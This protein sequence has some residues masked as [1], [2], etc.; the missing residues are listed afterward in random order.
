M[1]KV[2]IFNIKRNHFL[3]IDDKYWM[4]DVPEEVEAQREIASQARGEVLVAGYGLGIVQRLMS[5]ND[6]I[7]SILTIEKHPEVLEE[8]RKTYGRTYGRIIIEDF[9]NYQCEERYDCVIGDLWI[10]QSK[11]DLE[12]FSQFKKKANTLIKNNGQILGWGF[13]YMEDLLKKQHQ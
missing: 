2:E 13:D 5:D 4:C 7:N 1:T 12:T 11:K 10:D 3:Y 9:F 8:C 6:R